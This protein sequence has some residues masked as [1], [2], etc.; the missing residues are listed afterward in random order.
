MPTGCP[1][2]TSW[3]VFVQT[4]KARVWRAVCWYHTSTSAQGLVLM[5]GARLPAQTSAASVLAVCGGERLSPKLDVFVS[6]F[7]TFELWDPL[8]K[9]KTMDFSENYNFIFVTPHFGDLHIHIRFIFNAHIKCIYVIGMVLN[10]HSL[11][12]PDAYRLK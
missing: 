11:C 8:Y 6:C 1:F 12:S 4:E 9:I 10:K 7:E 5:R 3:M 2:S